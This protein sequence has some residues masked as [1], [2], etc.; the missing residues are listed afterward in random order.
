MY[1]YEIAPA[2][3][4]Y[5]GNSLLTYSSDE[6]LAPGQLVEISLRN[7]K[8]LGFIVQESSKPSFPTKPINGFKDLLL[9]T[10]SYD[11]FK[12]INDFY[13][14][15]PGASSQLFAPSYLA[16]KPVSPAPVT[17]KNIKVPLPPLNDE[18]NQAYE[19][20][21]A[22]PPGPKTYLLHGETGS[23]KTRLYIEL[24]KNSLS[25]GRSVVIL[26][27]EISLTAPLAKQLT[28]YFG[29]IV[30]IN[31]SGLSDKQRRGN[32]LKA[33]NTKLPLIAVGP[34][35]TIFSPLPDIGLIIID[36]F[37]DQAYKQDSA[38]YYMAARAASL[39]SNITGAKVVMGSATPS[40]SEYFIAK[41]K[42]IPILTMT[43][44]AV[45]GKIAQLNY[46]VVDL[47]KN[48]ERSRYP[49]IS[50]TLIE[51]LK[52]Q[53][54][55]GKQS[56]V[57]I[58][59]RGSARSVVCQSC[60]YRATCP[61]C[62]LPLAYHA[63]NHKLLCHTCGYNRELL[64]NCPVCRS[65]E[66]IFK[67]PG[68]KMIAENLAKLFPQAKIVR[69]DKDNLKAERMENNYSDLTSGETDII[70]GTQIITKGHDLPHLGLV[71][72]LQAETGLDFP[73]FSSEE[74]S[75]Q[76]IKQLM[77]RVNRGHTPGLVLLQTFDPLSPAIKYAAEN[78][79]HNFYQQQIEQRK[80]HGFPPFKH[81]LKIE[82]S[83]KSSSSVQKTLDGL[84]QKITASSKNLEILGPSPS[85]VER[86]SGDYSWQIIVKSSRRSD[87]AGIVSG[88]SGNYKANLDPI[89]FL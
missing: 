37:H 69:F 42:N 81:A 80:R 59:K 19:K 84:A 35:S 41:K 67:S 50:Q 54:S 36:E 34:R 11:F 17:T 26:T 68:T 58:N 72:I 66:I 3:K 21:M 28:D 38:P 49:L 39:L 16:G 61:N 79:W 70:I 10:A 65:S 55:A 52:H 24:A 40:I 56:M 14:G 77:G 2:D 23:G 51:Q 43:K 33:R 82:A 30:Q 13:P 22:D 12:A 32:W 48:Q 8:T 4:S 64:G 85:F 87:L 60:G 44:Q 89:N 57:F 78:N 5:R 6:K 88:L 18:Q 62:D 75:Y 45:S 7:K 20:I 71:A 46:Q 31:H 47:T 53:L 27:P 63:D 29:D 86:K 25:S 15:Y 1:Y 73:D 74:K 9:P 76:L 83:R